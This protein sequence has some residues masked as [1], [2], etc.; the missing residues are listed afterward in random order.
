MLLS[1]N[2]PKA[3]NRG[4][5]LSPKLKDAIKKYDWNSYFTRLFTMLDNIQ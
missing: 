2:R 5:S 1:I 3:V 4:I